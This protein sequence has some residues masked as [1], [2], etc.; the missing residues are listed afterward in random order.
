MTAISKSARAAGRRG[1]A[2]FIGYCAGVGSGRPVEIP[3]PGR[4]RVRVG[5][6]CVPVF[7]KCGFLA[8]EVG[9][10]KLGFPAL[11]ASPD[12]LF[13]SLNDFGTS[14]FS[15]SLL[16]A[17]RQGWANPQKS[18]VPWKPSPPIVPVDRAQLP[19]RLLRLSA[20]AE[21]S[22]HSATGGNARLSPSGRD[23]G[24]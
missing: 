16:G 21:E 20:S 5:S 3:S 18:P 19:T 24:T 11:P 15:T 23:P 4:V 22:A 6:R 9:L 2:V 14:Y 7:R 8:G 17:K 1:R 12:P 13:C 10:L